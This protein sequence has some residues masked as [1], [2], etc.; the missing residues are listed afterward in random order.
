MQNHTTLRSTEADII[1]AQVKA[2]GTP[3]RIDDVAESYFVLSA[4]QLL[5]LLR[6]EPLHRIFD[7][8]VENDSETSFTLDD[9]GLTEEHMAA[10]EERRKSRQMHLPRDSYT[11][12]NKHLEQRLQR[13]AAM[14]P[15]LSETQSAF[16]DQV[17]DELE[18][19]MLHAIK[20]AAQATA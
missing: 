20:A 9:F 14:L 2:H 8:D 7:E 19:Q 6:D 15:P 10:Y 11:G 17:V 16:R 3:L 1:L 12:L 4:G 5:L 18:V 13:A